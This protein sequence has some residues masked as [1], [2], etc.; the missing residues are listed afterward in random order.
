MRRTLLMCSAFRRRPRSAWPTVGRSP[1]AGLPSSTCMP[2]VASAT[3]WAC[4]LP[5]KRARPRSWSPRGAVF[6]SLPMDILDEDVNHPTPPASS[7][8][9]LG[10]SPDAARLAET[11]A[12]LDPDPVGVLLGDDQPAGARV[13]RVA[14]A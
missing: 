13:G 5:P 14:L 1:P 9:R 10:P 11:L 6:L 8:P 3:P 12:T 2:W 7:P 4:S